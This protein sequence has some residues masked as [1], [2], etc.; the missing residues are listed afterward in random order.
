MSFRS[1]LR[2]HFVKSGMLTE[3]RTE[4]FWLQVPKKKILKILP[5][6]ET[7]AVLS[8]S[9]LFLVSICISVLSEG[10]VRASKSEEDLKFYNLVKEGQFTMKCEE[11]VS[12]R[13]KK[14]VI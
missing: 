9:M 7:C 14:T 6:F 3:A 13:R 8:M 12:E 5:D 1:K 11:M 4:S 10:V 2:V